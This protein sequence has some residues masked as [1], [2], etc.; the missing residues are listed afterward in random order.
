MF[1]ESPVCGCGYGVPS[2]GDNISKNG[3]AKNRTLRCSSI[4]IPFG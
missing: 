1:Q 3:I 4:K 2:G